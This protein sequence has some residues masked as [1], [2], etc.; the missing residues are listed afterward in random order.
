MQATP[1]PMMPPPIGA[2]HAAEENSDSQ[3]DRGDRRRSQERQRRQIDV[4]G[5]RHAGLVGQHRQEVR[6]PDA[7]A[8]RGAGGRDPDRAGAT[9]RRT[10]AIE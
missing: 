5:D 6:R 3:A 7:A 4:V 10:G 8:G 2:P 9:R 1:A